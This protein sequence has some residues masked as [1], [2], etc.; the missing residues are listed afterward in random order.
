MRKNRYILY[1]FESLSVS[2]F[3]YHFRCNVVLFWSEKLPTDNVKTITRAF[4]W[5]LLQECTASTMDK[6]FILIEGKVIEFLKCPLQHQAQLKHKL[7]YFKMDFKRKWAASCRDKKNFRQ[8]NCTW[9]RGNINI[10]V[11]NNC[12]C[13]GRPS[14]S[15]MDSSIRMKQRKTKQLRGDVSVE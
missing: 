10:P 15:F 5:D 3:L 9:L 7:S 6:K 14:K 2:S 8:V 11:W 13:V 4:L 1:F 12:T